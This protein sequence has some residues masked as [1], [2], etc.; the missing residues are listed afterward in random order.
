MRVLLPSYLDAFGDASYS[1]RVKI[2]KQTSTGR[3]G[4]LIF[5]L[6]D[7]SGKKIPY[8]QNA[9][10]YDISASNGLEIAQS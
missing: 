5:R 2:T 1:A 8:V 9:F 7:P 4:A 3:F 6:Q 10:R